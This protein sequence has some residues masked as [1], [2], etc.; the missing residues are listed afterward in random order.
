MQRWLFGL[1]LFA[2]T[3]SASAQAGEMPCESC[4]ACLP[5]KRQ[6][7]G[8]KILACLKP[9]LCYRSTHC[10]EEGP[11]YYPHYPLYAY[12]FNDCSCRPSP[13]GSCNPIGTMKASCTHCVPKGR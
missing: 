5:Q 4:E 7:H 11:C 6:H 2:A 3:V 13:C 9:W 10:K 1:L 8:H 12:F